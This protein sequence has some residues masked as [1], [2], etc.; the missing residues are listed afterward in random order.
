MISLSGMTVNYGGVRALDG[1]SL[2]L[3]P[4]RIYGL[5]GPNGAGK[6]TAVNVITGV[7]R[8]VAGQMRLGGVDITNAP[9][10][11]RAR[12]GIARTFQNLALFPSLS[13]RE[14][15]ACGALRKGGY[16]KAVDEAL[17]AFSLSEYQH[18]MT[19]TLPLG[20]RKRVELARAL[21]SN[22]SLLLLDEPAAGLTPEDMSDLALRARG[23]REKGGTVLIVEHNMPLVMSLC[24]YIFVLEFGR[25]I[26]EG[27]PDEIKENELVQAAYFGSEREV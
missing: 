25:L 6:S 9:A 18:A 2:E 7:T 21:V 8:P 26:A 11:V 15:V 5:I 24:E 27:K 19:T 13:V 4:G 16:A 20:I 1:L 3:K 14:N 23:L 10:H 12:H 17:E 22:P